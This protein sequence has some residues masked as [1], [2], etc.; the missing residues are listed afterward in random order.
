MSRNV[1]DPVIRA[2][3]GLAWGLAVLRELFGVRRAVTR[4]GGKVTRDE[5]GES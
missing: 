5:E 2:S 1:A 4:R 3:G